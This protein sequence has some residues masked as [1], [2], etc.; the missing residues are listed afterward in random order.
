M[1]YFFNMPKNTN[2]KF[3]RTILFSI[4]KIIIFPFIFSIFIITTGCNSSNDVGEVGTTLNDLA[5]FQSAKTKWDSHSGQFYTIQS[6]RVCECDPEMSAQMKISVSDN[7]IISAFDIGS[8]DV[9]SKEIQEQIKTVDSLFALIE[10]AITDSV[11]IE[12]TYNEEFGYPETAK[13]DLEQLAVDG[14]LH[15]T[16]SNLEIKE[17]LLALDDVTWT[18]KSF[19]SIAGPQPII[20]NT[21]ISL[22]IDM[23]NMQLDGMGGCNNYSADFVLDDANHNMTISNIISTQLACNEPGNIMQQ[24]QRYFSILEQ[25][26]F[27]TFEKTTLNMVVGGDAGL[28]FEANQNSADEPKAGHSS[29]DLA[30]LQSAKTNWNSH[31]GQYYTIQSQRFCNCVPEMSAEMKISVLDNAILSAFDIGSDDVIPTAIREEIKTVDSLFALIEKAISESVSI[32]VT[33]NE[34]FGYPETAKIDLEKLAVDGG[35]HI[36]LSNI[37]IKNSL[38]ALDDVIWT[39]ESFDSIAGPKPV[40]ENTNIS[41]SI[42]LQNMQLVGMGGCNNYSADIVLDDEN[43]D[44]TISNVIFTERACDEPENI[45]QQEQNYFSTLGQVRFFAFDKAIL[46]MVVGGDAGLHFVAAD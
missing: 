37:E 36:T 35:L 40:I 25:I 5:L 31:S 4:R 33:Y 24:E 39:L 2:F 29:N 41:M 20:E 30:L 26:Q 14:G 19:D 8:D 15:I 34:E 23:Q 9:I 42:D 13:I 3:S 22:S 32:E 38:H 44:I 21:N 27:F 7:V 28:N 45:M 16:L 6:Q 12:V 11:S 17:S 43:H 10:K 46:N 1:T 18:L